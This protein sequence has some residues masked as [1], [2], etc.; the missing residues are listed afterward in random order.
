MWVDSWS[1][2]ARVVVVLGGNGR[3]SV[4]AMSELG[5]GSSLSGIPRPEK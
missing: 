2:V 1:D 4:I 5:S 3:I